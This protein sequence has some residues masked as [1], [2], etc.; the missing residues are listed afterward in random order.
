MFQSQLYQQHNMQ[1]DST[2]SPSY[3]VPCDDYVHVVEFSP[4]SSGIPASLLAYGGNQFVVVG[5]CL[6][7]VR[8]SSSH[9]HTYQLVSF[10]LQRWISPTGG[11]HGGG[12]SWIQCSS[13]VSSRAAGRFSG[14]ESRVSAGQDPHCQVD[15][16]IL[17]VLKNSCLYVI[18][19][20]WGKQHPCAG[21]QF[22]FM[23]VLLMSILA[24]QVL[25]HC[26]N[27]DKHF[28]WGVHLV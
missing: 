13:S 10:H 21:V 27:Q 26:S 14:L 28:A 7:Q 4:F 3:T 2:R 8:R 24:A 11:G 19:S 15:M 6:F 25:L 12:G 5:T 16:T 17:Y 18:H 20:V 9:S 1:E 23:V 22:I